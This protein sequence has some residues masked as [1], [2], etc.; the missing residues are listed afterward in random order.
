MT[1]YILG[2]TLGSMLLIVCFIFIS[3]KL[4]D[5]KTKSNLIKRIGMKAEK[6]INKDIKEWARLTQNKFIDSNF[7]KYN[8]KIF[9]V[10][11]ILI[12]DKALIVIVIKSIKGHISGDAKKDSWT[13]IF[14]DKSFPILNS[15]KQNDK[16]IAHITEMLQ[17]NV[18]TISLIIYS[19]NTDYIDILNKPNYAI[20][21]KHNK[22]FEVLDKINSSLPIRISNQNKKIIYNEIKH[23]KTNKLKDKKLYKSFFQ[24]NRKKVY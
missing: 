23:F 24:I 3:R 17:M 1:G 22:L 7:Y 10:N 5:L 9:E 2:M 4:Y 6:I 13:K 19:N 18:P 11:S 8:N 15:I 12:T 20:I 14:G 21:T 16:H